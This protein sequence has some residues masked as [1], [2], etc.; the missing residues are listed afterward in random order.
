M[1]KQ[2]DLVRLQGQLDELT[3]RVKYII[4]DRATVEVTNLPLT[5]ILPL[6]QLTKI[7]EED[8]V[9]KR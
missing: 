7:K 8:Y 2:G 9:F 4:N 5:T 3:Y 6:E 1:I